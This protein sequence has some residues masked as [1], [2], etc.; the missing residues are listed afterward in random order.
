MYMIHCILIYKFNSVLYIKLCMLYV[1]DSLMN[2]G[3]NFTLL[4]LYALI[5]EYD[6]FRSD[7]FSRILRRLC[8]CLGYF[9]PVL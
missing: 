1:I 7:S 6:I 8:Y 5:L 9:I 2:S 4:L 3:I